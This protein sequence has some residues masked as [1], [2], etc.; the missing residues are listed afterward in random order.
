MAA[1][2]FSFGF[3]GDDIDVDLDEGVPVDVAA[4]ATASTT[5]AAGA[6]QLEPKVH[7][8]GGLLSTL[9][10]KVSYTTLTILTLKGNTIKIPRRELFDIRMQLM[11]EDD[12]DSA[13]LADLGNDD[14]RANV[15]EGGLKSW[16]C[17]VDLVRVL[18][19][20]GGLWGGGEERLKVMELGS[21]TA[22][23]TLYLFQQ[24]LI[25]NTKNPHFSISDYN[26]DVL[27]LVTIPNLLLS[28]A[29]ITGAI[30]DPWPTDDDLEISPGLLQR[31]TADLDARGIVVDILS[32]AWGLRFIEL[33][34]VKPWLVLASETIYSPASLP[35]FVQT[36][37]EVL[38][39]HGSHAARAL[40]AA[41]MVYFG[42]GG[43]VQEFLRL[44]RQEYGNVGQERYLFDTFEVAEKSGGVARV[45]L[46]L[47]VG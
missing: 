22:L 15:Y 24:V 14:I 18:V 42:V 11:A 3:S 46:E 43:G 29:M 26:A 7:G 20:D 16:E 47:P 1:Q 33:V 44:L 19:D 5:V 34:H 6:A 40:V 23:P 8:L 41:K 28:W 21:G 10:S 4:T 13:L 31:F 17:S 36:L 32:G 39:R 27:R 37:V 12:E 38:D 25:R 35:A 30:P 9:P 2:P 45:V